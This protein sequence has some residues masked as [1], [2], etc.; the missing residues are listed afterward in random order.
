MK[1]DV[2]YL[3]RAI[4]FQQTVTFICRVSSLQ[5]GFLTAFPRCGLTGGHKWR[6]TLEDIVS[7]GKHVGR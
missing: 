7:A 3:Q 6:R 2:L 1:Y 4:N 5:D